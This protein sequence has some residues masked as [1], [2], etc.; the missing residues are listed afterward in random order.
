[1]IHRIIYTWRRTKAEPEANEAA[2]AQARA[3]R[4][5]AMREAPALLSRTAHRGG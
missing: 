4:D 2:I 1:V 5:A 3:Q